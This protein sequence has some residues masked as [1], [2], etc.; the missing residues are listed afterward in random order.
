MKFAKSDLRQAMRLRLGTLSAAH[1][2]SASEEL[3]D[4]VRAQIRWQES[5]S[6]LLFVPL[7]DEPDV[8]PLAEEA[9][10]AGRRLALPRFDPGRQAYVACAVK[11]LER[12]LA[13]G[14]F[15]I[16]EPAPHLD[17]VPISE[18]DLAL[19][20]GLAFDLRGQRLG[21]GKGFYDRLLAEVSGHRCGVAF[22]FQVTAELP[23][24]PHDARLHSLATEAGWKDFPGA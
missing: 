18:V 7:R 17:L 2:A 16:A 11:D 23:S 15:G 19:A 20:P 14:R 24:E 21:R 3:C 12:D 6:V 9:L 13:P 22:E 8:W 4:H 5:T 10:A 1:R